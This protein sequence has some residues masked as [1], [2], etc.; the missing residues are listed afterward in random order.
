M[1]IAINDLNSLFS[2]R[3]TIEYIGEEKE[4]TWIDS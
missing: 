3:I 2:W 4:K 1:K